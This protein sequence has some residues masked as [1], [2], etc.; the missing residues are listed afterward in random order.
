MLKELVKQL[1]T[2]DANFEQLCVISVWKLFYKSSVQTFDKG[3]YKM[4]ANT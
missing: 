4:F 3:I 1:I 2:A